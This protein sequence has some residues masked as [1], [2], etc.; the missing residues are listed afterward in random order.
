[1]FEDENI[2]FTTIPLL[3]RYNWKSNYL[4]G[5]FYFLIDEVNIAA[6]KLKSVMTLID[7][8]SSKIMIEVYS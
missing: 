1:M 5:E 6:D 2:D 7:K 3:Q 4:L 8:K